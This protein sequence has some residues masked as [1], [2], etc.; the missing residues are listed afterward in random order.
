[1]RRRTWNQLLPAALAVV[2]L[3][4]SVL[5]GA[6]SAQVAGKSDDPG[7]PAVTAAVIKGQIT[8]AESGEPLPY[9]N[10]YIAGTSIGTMAFDDGYYIL[11]GL[12]PGTYTIRA[13]Y[14][15]YALG[16]A[17]VTVSAGESLRLDFP[18]AVEAIMLN[19]YEISAERR[20]IEVERTGSSHYLSSHQLSSM[21]LDDVTEMIAHEPG[22]TIYDNEIHI[23][24]GRAD[25]TQFIIDGMSVNDPLA[26]GGYGYTI[27]PT[28]INEIEVL[29]GG[30]NAEYGQAVSGVVNVSTKE[31]DERF[32]GRVA[33]KR[34][35][36]WRPVPKDDYLGWRD[37]SRF[38]EP[39]NIDILQMTLSGP[40]PLSGALD[41]LGLGLPGDQYLLVSGSLDLRDGYLPIF[42]RQHQLDSPIY[43]DSFWSPR[44][45][46]DWD[47]LVK[48]TWHMTPS[49]KLNI[50]GS[51]HVGISQGFNL[52]GEG[53]PR[54]FIEGL[55]RYLVFTSENILTQVQYRQVL[56]DTD[57]F[58]LSLGRNF[59]R[60]HANVNGVDDFSQ[61]TPI[62]VLYNDPALQARGSADRWHDHYTETYEVKGAFSFM[63]STINKFKTGF[64]LAFTE[65]QL[66]DLKSELGSPP[67]GK[68]GIDQDIF[69][70][71]PIV[72][73]AYFQ[74]TIDY[75]GLIV[76]AGLRGDFW[77]PGH[78]V[79]DV[80]AH[81][82]QYLFIYPDMVQEFEDNTFGA[83]GRRWKARLSP[84]LGLSFPVTERDK[85]FFNY[86]HFSQW[87][88]FAYVYPQ[89]RAETAVEVQQLGN[90]N[91][92]PKVTVE[93]ET[94]I[95]HAFGGLWSMGVTFFNRDIYDYAKSV[96]ME[97]VNIGPE[98]TPDP[99]D[100]ETITISP[101]RYF[102]GDSAR[103]LGVEL[104]LVK[105]TTR[106]L[107]GSANLE[108][109]SSTGTNSRADEA[110][111][112]AIYDEAYQPTASIG[113][114]T[115]TPLLWDRPWSIS[116]NL[117]FS[118]GERPR[119]QLGLPYPWLSSRFPFLTLRDLPL[120]T[121]PSNWSLNVLFQAEAG[122]R[123][124]PL[125]Y[126]GGGRSIRG[127]IN[128]G[129]GPTQNTLN[130]R[131]NKYWSVGGGMRLT[132][133]LE[134]RNILNHTNYRRVNPYTG[135]G[136]QVG[137]YDP[138]WEYQWSDEENPITT[139]SEAYAKGEIRPDYVINPRTLM[140]G[141]SYSW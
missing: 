17:T 88:R 22:V 138:A 38:E 81:Q 78:E 55:D 90:P 119:P 100:T 66:V 118:V 93:Y 121:L 135:E 62:D 113:G 131:L 83:L 69:Q 57:W 134:G 137:N 141:V 52:P 27:D 14:I 132:L 101:V 33:L 111:L 9:T 7:T 71:H 58:E 18:L 140:W 139:D 21:P 104:S 114:L 56:S 54:P 84:R 86:G 91:L 47:G 41:R 107:S 116:V 99:N 45:D 76:N 35:Y 61:Y 120:T 25:D 15:S 94:G 42:S 128:S 36:G 46:N 2:A 133:F 28:L 124:T 129:V 112:Q 24:G 60:L 8:D 89:L 110:Y 40:D 30:F 75:H 68:L 50:T 48:W 136:Y 79:E 64:D 97:Q 34:D 51:R 19:P 73:A 43:K 44:Q 122:Q 31:G 115:R 102:N 126:E 125:I 39:Q 130:L 117:D 70:A 26:G 5:P 82:D 67:S 105:R 3:A 63:R 109:Q 65:M 20:L 53:Y 16:T 72:G 127:D 96:Q 12:A 80:L 106:W 29:T 103:S 49:H 11:H 123:Y 85:F 95:Q 10:V 32:S 1:V 108:L 98:E 87:P 74:D 92:D 23:R 59:N 77:A 37:L 4:G 6:V 13:A